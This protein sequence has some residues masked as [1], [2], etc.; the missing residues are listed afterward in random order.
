M[1]DIIKSIKAFLYDR[2][3]SPLFG[4]FIIS[5]LA[6]NHRVVMVVFSGNTNGAKFRLMDSLLETTIWGQAVEWAPLTVKL[7]N[8]VYIPFSIALAYIFIYPVIAIPV[9]WVALFFQRVFK[10]MKQKHSNKTLLSTEESN[11]M[12]LRM[13]ELEKKTTADIDFHRKQV[14]SL[15]D[16]N[17]ELKEKNSELKESYTESVN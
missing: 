7:A 13:A 4:A 6:W 9:Y 2:S 17:S 12:F 15:T 1:E 5:L 8:V 10:K 3:A 16:L 11:E 14:S